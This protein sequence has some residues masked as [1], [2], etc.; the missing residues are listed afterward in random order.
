MTTRLFRPNA[1]HV[2]YA[3]AMCDYDGCDHAMCAPDDVAAL[4][5]YSL[6]VTDSMVTP[7]GVAWQ[8]TLRCGDLAFATVHQDGRGGCNLYRPLADGREH[9]TVFAHAA[10][11]AFPRLASEHD[12]AA[13]AFLDFVAAYEAGEL[14]Q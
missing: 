8:G 10:R 12:D 14:E 5:N 6:T 7:D 2:T 3:I 11:M 9:L 1:D 4:A 13:V